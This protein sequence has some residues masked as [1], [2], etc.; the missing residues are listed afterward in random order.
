M[1]VMEK[2]QK[3]T[4]TYFSVRISKEIGPGGIGG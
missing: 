3:V 4:K 1:R 2:N